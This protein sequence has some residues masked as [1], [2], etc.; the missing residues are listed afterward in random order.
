MQQ[1]EWDCELSK[2]YDEAASQ[3][4]REK[5][6]VLDGQQRLQTLYGIFYG[7]IDG[8][9]G[10]TPYMAYLDVTKGAE[11]DEDGLH[12]KLE[13]RAYKLEFRA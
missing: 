5:I 4:G 12:H 8:P 2:Y 11:P 9:D 3:L 6:F 7:C 1:I 13:F 10:T